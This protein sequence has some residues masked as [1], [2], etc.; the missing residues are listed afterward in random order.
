MQNANA[1][2]IYKWYDQS[3]PSLLVDERMS[4]HAA[5]FWVRNLKDGLE[6]SK[7]HDHG[8]LSKGASLLSFAYNWWRVNLIYLPVPGCRTTPLYCSKNVQR[9]NAERNRE[10]NQCKLQ[11]CSP[12]N[13]TYD[14]VAGSIL[15]AWV[16]R[17]PWNSVMSRGHLIVIRRI[18]KFIHFQ[19][20]VKK[21]G[22]KS[23]MCQPF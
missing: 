5:H 19:L 6:S 22:P 2:T 3:S 16:V 7:C 9:E 21:T 15:L 11:K 10:R 8:L 12:T 14:W 17:F 4:L 18:A 1:S 13:L 23:F 20:Q